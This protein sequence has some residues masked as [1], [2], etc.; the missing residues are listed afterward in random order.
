[1]HDTLATLRTAEHIQAQKSFLRCARALL[2]A[3]TPAA[4]NKG[5]PM[6]TCKPLFF[7]GPCRL[8]PRGRQTRNPL[9]HDL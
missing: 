3:L 6:K 5:T 4:T 7:D 1:M 8:V 2:N 9:G